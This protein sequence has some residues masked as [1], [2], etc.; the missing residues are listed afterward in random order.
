MLEKS[1]VM[2]KPEFANNNKVIVEVK[3]RLQNAGLKIIKESFVWYD[4]NHARKHY[5]EHVG[6]DFY[7]SLESYI[8]SDKAYGMIVEGENA[9]E[10]IRSLAG[11]TKSPQ[12][13]TLRY[14]IPVM[15][16]IKPNIT[17]NVVH[18][19]DSKD[20]ADKEIAIFEQL[21]NKAQK[22]E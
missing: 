17:K 21:I 10:K 22:S 5:A 9:I 20:S 18:S 15:L 6:K 7:P 12:I 1:Y 8:T 19:S 4:V 2:I 11:A 3:A 14:D 16:N 13:G